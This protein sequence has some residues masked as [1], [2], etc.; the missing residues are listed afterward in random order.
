VKKHLQW[1]WLLLG[2]VLGAGLGLGYAWVIHPAG[3]RGAEP[4]SLQPIY[5]GEYIL[6]I[7]TAYQATGNLERAR[8]RIESFPELDADAL[9]SLAQQVVASSGSADAARGLASLSVALLEQTPLPPPPDGTSA[10]GLSPTIRLT[11]SANTTL[12]LT[13][14]IL[15]TPTGKPTLFS[16]L[17]PPPGFVLV[18]HG[19][20]CNAQITRPLIQV[21]VRT[22]GGKGVPGIS[23]RIQWEGGGSRFVTGMKP[24]LGAGYADYEIEPG[25]VYQIAVGDGLFV[26]RDIVAPTCPAATAVAGGTASPPFTGSWKLVFETR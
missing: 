25:K 2:L 10:P 14:P 9:S 18:D 19:Q 11:P 12:A 24:E 26:V 15:P 13:V 4:A 21:I 7:A 16:T 6:L 5:R 1:L 8:V 20:I 3:F 17:T 23:I 22:P